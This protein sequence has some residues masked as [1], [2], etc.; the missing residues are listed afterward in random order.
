LRDSFWLVDI[1]HN[2]APWVKIP[3]CAYR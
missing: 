2:A 3:D 1:A